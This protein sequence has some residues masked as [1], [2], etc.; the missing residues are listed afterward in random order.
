MT[1]LCHIYDLQKGVQQGQHTHTR[2]TTQPFVLYTTISPP[3]HPL[4]HSL[5]R[6]DALVSC[7]SL[8]GGRGRAFRRARARARQETQR[9]GNRDDIAAL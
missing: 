4:T 5:F 2:T 7:P 9:N 6:D 3:P 8:A 1:T